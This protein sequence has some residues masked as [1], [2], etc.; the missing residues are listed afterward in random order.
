MDI[1]FKLVTTVI[2]VLF[3]TTTTCR[4]TVGLTI[5]SK[6][7]TYEVGETIL[8]N[9]TTSTESASDVQWYFNSNLIPEDSYNVLPPNLSQLLI[10]NVN[11]SHAGNY[12]CV[13]LK[14]GDRSQSDIDIKV[15]VKPFPAVNFSCHSFNAD[16]ILCTWDEGGTHNIPTN[17]TFMYKAFYRQSWVSD[18]HSN[19]WTECPDRQTSTNCPGIHNFT[20]SCL[21]K[22]FD[23]HLGSRQNVSLRVSNDLGTTSTSLSFNADIEATPFPPENVKVTAEG[24]GCLKTSW[25]LPCGWISMWLY[26]Q[27]KVRW[28]SEWEPDHWYSMTNQDLRSQKI[29]NLESFT[30]YNIQVSAGLA[31]QQSYWSDWTDTRI[32]KTLEGEPLSRLLVEV[33]YDDTTKLDNRRDVTVSWEPLSKREMKGEV[34][35]YTVML[36]NAKTNETKTIITMSNTTSY[37]FTGLDK[38]RTYT[39]T[40]ETFNNIGSS[41]PSSIQ[42]LE[43][44][45]AP[46]EPMNVTASNINNTSIDVRWKPP[47]N[48]HGDII[49]YN[50]YCRNSKTHVLHVYTVIISDMNNDNLQYQIT[51]LEEF[52]WYEIYVQAFNKVGGGGYSQFSHLY[53]LGEL[54]HPFGPP[55]LVKI[56]SLKGKSSSL[57]VVWT[58]PEPVDQHKAQVQGYLLYYC[59]VANKNK[60]NVSHVVCVD[61]ST[62]MRNISSMAKPQQELSTEIDGLNPYTLYGVWMAAYTTFGIPGPNSTTVVNRTGQKSA[63]EVPVEQQ[64]PTVEI[65]S[66]ERKSPST[67]AIIF[68]TLS[69]LICAGA[70]FAAIAIVWVK[71]QDKHQRPKFETQTSIDTLLPWQNASHTESTYGEEEQDSQQRNTTMTTLEIKHDTV[72]YLKDNVVTNHT[73]F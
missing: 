35:G 66:S 37:E 13:L 27:Y 60:N 58:P 55:R 31:G 42:V 40:V 22:I 36:E 6:K 21:L 64:N 11:F 68:I 20:H 65:V 38:Y 51:G 70:G 1:T 57:R 61:D 41:P 10:T 4:D 62:S 34:L 18:H 14:N 59:E 48:S 46:T 17:Y 30:D 29:C 54:V 52:V 23:D 33:M 53:T 44:M 32:A 12:S 9:C 43:Q 15:G 39:I 7:S 69:V 56:E 16:D 71:R 19:E 24:P 49:K 63:T 72:F 50:V 26:L 28:A 3:T 5:S 73:H 2:L 47:L 25:E 8:V 67:I 45:S